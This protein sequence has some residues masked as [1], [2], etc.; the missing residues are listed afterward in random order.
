MSSI[1]NMIDV[2]YGNTNTKIVKLLDLL[3]QQLNRMEASISAIEDYQFAQI[4]DREEEWIQ[5]MQI[6]LFVIL[7]LT[8]LMIECIMIQ[9]QLVISVKIAG[10]DSAEIQL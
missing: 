2:M 8:I 1:D 5:K 7:V 3:K 6:V 9:L 10:V 4:K